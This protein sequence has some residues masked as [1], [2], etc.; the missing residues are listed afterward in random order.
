MTRRSRK[1]V[2]AVAMLVFVIVYA[3][4]VMSLAQ[5]RLQDAGNTAQTIFY[6]VAGL[7]WVLPLMPL[8][9]WMERPDPE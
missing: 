7:S 6:L 1:F 2:G 8:I 5:G 3:L 9:R 4:A